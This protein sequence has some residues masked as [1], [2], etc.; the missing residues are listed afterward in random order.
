MAGAPMRAVPV[1]YAQELLNLGPGRG[2]KSV[3]IKSPA[4]YRAHKLVVSP[5]RSIEGNDFTYL[6]LSLGNGMVFSEPASE[7]QWSV[8]V[9]PAGSATCTYDDDTTDEQEGD[10]EVSY[11]A[12]YSPDGVELETI[13]SSGGSPGDDYVVFRLDLVGINALDLDGN[14]A[15]D[16]ESRIPLTLPMFDAN[17]ADPPDANEN[18]DPADDIADNNESESCDIPASKVMLW[19]DVLDHLAIPVGTGAYS[20]S[21]SL[22]TDPDDAQAGVGATSALT[23][24]ATIVRAVDGLEVTVKASERPAVAHVGTSPE[25]FLWFHD[26]STATGTTNKAILGYATAQIEREDLL[27]PATGLVAT[28][29]DLIPDDSLTVGIE[30]DFSIGAFNL[31]AVDN[32]ADAC[33]DAGAPTAEGPVMGNLT[34]AEGG[35]AGKAVLAE[36]DAGTYHLCVQVD[37]LGPNSTPIPAGTYYGTITQK[38]G[39]LAKELADGVIGQIRRNGTTV[40]LAYLTVAEKYDQ[41]L[42]IAN[43]G[44]NDARYDIGPFMTEDGVT[45]TPQSMASGVVPAGEQIVV[46]VADIVSFSSADGRRHR[47]AAT[48]SMNAHVDDVQVATTQVNL[49]DGSTDTVVY[50]TVDRPIVQ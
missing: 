18:D 22:H 42:V 11:P 31:L 33:L 15:T 47:A 25:P 23:G 27:N 24:A 28:S 35:P 20:A 14:A 34:P 3:S 39:A 5:N 21:I 10:Q 44:A 2:L 16:A 49:E 32:P 7:I 37:V 13:H 1:T 17:E 12:G 40:N 36:Q 30:G 48:L 50:A 45:A 9:R 19:V 41:R 4:D 43:D 38:T 8:G 6:R 46:P 26:S 29:S